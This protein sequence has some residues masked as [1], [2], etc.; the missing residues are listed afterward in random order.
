MATLPKYGTRSSTPAAMPHTA[1]CSM[2]M[3]MKL[4][5]VATPTMKLVNSCTGM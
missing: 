1:A 5:Q 3:A 2:P 4:S